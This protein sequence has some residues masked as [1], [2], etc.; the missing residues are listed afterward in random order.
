MIYRCNAWYLLFRHATV[1]TDI[2]QM[3][4]IRVKFQDTFEF[5]VISL[6]GGWA[7]AFTKIR[8]NCE[9]FFEK[10][11]EVLFC[12]YPENNAIVP[13]LESSLVGKIVCAIV[14]TWMLHFL[15]NAIPMV[16]FC[17]SESWT[18]EIGIQDDRIR[19]SVNLFII[20]FPIVFLVQFGWTRIFSLHSSRLTRE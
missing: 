10:S 6:V 17:P 4:L 15:H 3:K 11:P 19:G 7:R 16:R 5:S 18:T 20:L 1:L 12:Y 13:Y 8:K 14:S 9:L 2:G